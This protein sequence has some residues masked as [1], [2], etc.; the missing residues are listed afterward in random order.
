MIYTSYFD[1]LKNLP[2]NVIPVAICI[3]EPDWYKGLSYKKLAPKPDFFKKWRVT[4]DNEYYEK[5]FQEQVLGDLDVMETLSEIY[6]LLP[7]DKIMILEMTNC[8]PWQNP[9][10]NIALICYEL[11][12]EFCHRN[13]VSKW[14]NENKLVKC[15]EWI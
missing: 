1:N 8:P 14:L 9:I 10:V 13:L 5:C 6:S 2:K 12:G 4:R 11:P 3:K 15:E 7:E